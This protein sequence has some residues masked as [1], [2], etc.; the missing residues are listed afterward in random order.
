MS[1]HQKHKWFFSWSKFTACIYPKY[2][3]IFTCAQSNTSGPTHL[4]HSAPLKATTFVST[5]INYLESWNR[6]FQ[7]GEFKGKLFRKDKNIDLGG[8]INIGAILH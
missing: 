4:S 7:T 8:Y 2:F 6:T 5:A 1:G 3:S